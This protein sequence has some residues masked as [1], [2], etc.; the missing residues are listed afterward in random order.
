MAVK[1][2][3]KGAD[4]PAPFLWSSHHIKTL[5]DRMV[6]GGLKYRVVFLF[7]KEAGL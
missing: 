7:A 5:M 4:K 3:N 6:N 1:L 2:K